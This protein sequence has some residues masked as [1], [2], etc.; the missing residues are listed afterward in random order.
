MTVHID[1]FGMIAPEAASGGESGHWT[2]ECV[3]IMANISKEMRSAGLSL[4]GYAHHEEDVHNHW[5]KEFDF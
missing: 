5:L 3:R 2:Y 4:V 1:E